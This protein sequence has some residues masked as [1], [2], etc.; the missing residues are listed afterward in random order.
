M[1]TSFKDYLKEELLREQAF[2]AKGD[3]PWDYGELPTSKQVTELYWNL[4]DAFNIKNVIYEVRNMDESLYVVGTWLKE[5]DEEIFLRI[6]EIELEKEMICNKEYKSVRS[7]SVSKNY[8]GIGI[9]L[10]L[11]KT[12]VK[13]IGLNLVSDITQYFGTRKLWAKLSRD[14][15]LTVDI[16]DVK[17]CQIQPSV[18]IK[19]GNVNDSF[20]KS[21]WGTKDS[22]Y[23]T[24]S[25]RM[26]LKDIE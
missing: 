26:I 10:N 22:E 11:Y 24:D 18:I 13:T 1:Q 12:L 17:T 20:D 8:R 16:I 6:A 9:A 15:I 7:V 14:P 2:A 5:N 4:A 23:V 3:D 19:H 21:V 25:I